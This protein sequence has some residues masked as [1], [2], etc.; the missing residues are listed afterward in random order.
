[1]G[2]EEDAP[3]GPS[4]PDVRICDVGTSLPMPGDYESITGRIYD[5]TTM[6]GKIYRLSGKL[7]DAPSIRIRLELWDGYGAFASTTAHPGSFQLGGADASA[8]TCGVCAYVVDTASSLT[9]LAVAGDIEVTQ[10]GSSFEASLADL[11]LVQIDTATSEI[12]ADACVHMLDSTMLASTL[13]ATPEGLSGAG[14]G[15]D[16]AGGSDND[17]D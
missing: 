17:N 12:P 5:E 4:D 13:A 1:M 10:L 7:L 9:M 15:G 11:E 6:T 8:A 16:G 2:F 14:H 3:I